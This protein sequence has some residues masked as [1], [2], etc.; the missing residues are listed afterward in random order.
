MVILKEITETSWLVLS[1]KEKERIGLLSAA[2]TGVYSF[3]SK[4]GKH[5]FEN[6][7]KVADFF[8]ENIFDQ[9]VQAEDADKQQNFIKGYP[10]SYP[11]PVEADIDSPLPLFK[12]TRQSSVHHCAGYYCLR[13]PKGWIHSYC[14]KLSTVEKYEHAGPFKTNTE[15]K[16]HLSALRRNDK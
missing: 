8:A 9:V 7:Q 10:I 15:M 13:F 3:L 5:T 12:K 14:P 6:K 11:D 2:P 1:D 4:D 16:A